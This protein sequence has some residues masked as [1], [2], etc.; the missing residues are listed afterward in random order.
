M[1][2]PGLRVGWLGSFALVLAG[3]SDAPRPM[4]DVSRALQTTEASRFRN[5]ATL[6]LDGKVLLVGGAAKSVKGAPGLGSAPTA[7]AEL[8]DPVTG[9]FTDVGALAHGRWGHT[10]TL[11]HDGRVL[12][13]G[14]VDENDAPLASAELYD[15]TTSSFAEA[16]RLRRPR[17]LHTATL[18]AD[19]RVLL[20]GGVD[21]LTPSAGP[22]PYAVV[23]DAVVPTAEVFV[24]QAAR[25]D[26]LSK[27]PGT[28]F[29][30]A[31]ILLD[32][33]RVAIAWPKLG[34]NAVDLALFDP[35]RNAFESAD[36][37]P[38]S[39]ACQDILLRY[40]PASAAEA[41]DVHGQR[42][43][44]ITRTE[45]LQ[46]DLSTHDFAQVSH[47]S[48][49]ASLFDDSG[50]GAS[51]AMALGSS[52]LINY[53]DNGTLGP[54][55]V[56]AGGWWATELSQREALRMP[57]TPS[58]SGAWRDA[59]ELAL[60]RAWSTA[61]S[62]PSGDVLVAGG[63][64]GAVGPAIEQLSVA[65]QRKTPGRLAA[66]AGVVFNDVP[67]LGEAISPGHAATLLGDGRVL[68]TGGYK[69][70]KQA[71]TWEVQRGSSVDAS[72]QGS[73]PQAAG[74]LLAQRARHLGFL[75]PSGQVL[76]AG[77]E[78]KPERA[79]EELFDLEAHES[80]DLGFRLQARNS[81][82]AVGNNKYLFAGKAGLELVDATDFSVRKFA[83]PAPLVCAAPGI[84]RLLNGRVAVLGQSFIFELDLQQGKATVPVQLATPRCDPALAALPDGTLAIEGG[85]AADL[86]AN[87][88]FESYD[89]VTRTLSPAGQLLNPLA[90]ARAIVR[91]SNLVLLGGTELPAYP[92]QVVNWQSHLGSGVFTNKVTSHGPSVTTLADGGIL[93]AS[94]VEHANLD[95]IDT[96]QRIDLM[97]TDSS[98]LK[99]EEPPLEATPGLDIELSGL[100]LAKTWPE[101][102]GGGTQASATNQPVAMWVPI[103]DGWPV[104][105][106]F[107]EWSEDHATW[108]VP[109]VALPG[110][111]ILG[112]VRS[113]TLH[114][115]RLVRVNELGD[116]DACL[117]GSECASSYCIDG[118][119][120]D[121]ACD[122]TC[123]ACSAGRKAAGSD[124]SC[125]PASAETPEMACKDENVC[126]KT[127]LCDGSGACALVPE[128]ASC[129]KGLV[130]ISSRVQN[131]CAEPTVTCDG[132]HTLVDST[133][134]RSSCPNNFRCS[135]A[136]DTCIPKCTSNGECIDGFFC[137][138][139][140]ECQAS[141]EPART[142]VGCTPGCRL[143]SNDSQ[144]SEIWAIALGLGATALRRRSRRAVA[145]TSRSAL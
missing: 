78:T 69:V 63:V 121:R 136:H 60:P 47:Q 86:T 79:N 67:A 105:G 14:G 2:S 129:G 1:S 22:P 49:A 103:L 42:L 108:R 84:A 111:G 124:G 3:C 109:R 25:F 135:Q 126:G 46:L 8:F 76:L 57:S 89:P 71:L 43:S 52:L 41:V 40:E 48:G 21:D 94:L 102:S 4:L 13:A 88:T 35:A 19:D 99:L 29:P 11:L 110:L 62:L 23:Y 145:A 38:C 72:A 66:S 34:P 6:L 10:A 27:R 90:G 77:G 139:G 26:E 128:G 101:N 118:V 95:Q 144:A 91:F 81:G 120:C 114:P 107:T 92:P 82:L 37:L 116:G 70:S 117:Q 58:D 24:P 134:K 130:C 141:V 113:G 53:A 16:G 74:P 125:G 98:D 54:Q 7:S 132:D 30:H 36:E 31:A 59:G 45:E 93:L 112:Y 15:P 123:E 61:T 75:L 39:A 18:L 131:F 137:T 138:S 140:G 106:T 20:L 142:S 119:C 64:L 133:G 68:F 87:P 5:T 104:T 33:G 32:D 97:T 65:G 122:G 73:T 55:P 12:V 143:A 80:R 127:G 56:L 51:A 85:T 28:T 9:S 17:A 100:Q 115:L 44:V 50:S 96:P 83:P